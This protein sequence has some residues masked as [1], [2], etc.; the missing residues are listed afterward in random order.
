[1]TA[2][3]ALNCP[4]GHAACWGCRTLLMYCLTVRL[5]C[6][7]CS[8][9]VRLPAAGPCLLLLPLA[10]GGGCGGSWLAH[11]FAPPHSWLRSR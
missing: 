5:Y 2:A 1:M 8:A 4:R 9:L 3:H 6:L 7:H 10:V 11:A